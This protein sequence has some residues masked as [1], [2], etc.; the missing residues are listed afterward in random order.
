MTSQHK[1]LASQHKV[2]ASQH[3]DMTRRH[4]AVVLADDVNTWSCKDMLQG[5]LTGQVLSVFGAYQVEALIQEFKSYT[6]DVEKSMKL[7]N[8]KIDSDIMLIK[9]QVQIQDS[10]INFFFLNTRSFLFLYTF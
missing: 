2:L 1:V 4:I 10:G 8:D 3:K 7:L 9:T 6:D 5:Y